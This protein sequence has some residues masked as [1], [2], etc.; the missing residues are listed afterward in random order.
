[1]IIFLV[2]LG[3]FVLGALINFLGWKLHRRKVKEETSIS[4]WFVEVVLRDWFG[5][6]TGPDSTGG[7]RLAAFGAI[8]TG[9]GLVVTM[10]G[11]GVWAVG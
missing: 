7:E 6:L 1:M 5:R 9:L 2:G 11:I 8:L 3:L 4:R 10:A